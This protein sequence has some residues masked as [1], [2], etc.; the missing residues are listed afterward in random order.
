[1]YYALPMERI[2]VRELRNQASQVVRRARSGERL[3]ITVDGVPAPESGSVSGTEREGTR[4]SP[5]RRAARPRRLDE[6]PGGIRAAVVPTASAHDPAT[7][8]GVANR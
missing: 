2:A 7:Y 3:I 5:S 4:D 1:M 6:C 8:C